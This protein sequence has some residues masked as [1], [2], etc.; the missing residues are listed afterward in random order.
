M[1]K[2]KY[3]ILTFPGHL[4]LIMD[5]SQVLCTGLSKVLDSRV[6]QVLLTVAQIT[7]FRL[8][9]LHLCDF[10]SYSPTIRLQQ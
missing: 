10:S 1:Q 2:R 6:P 4:G 8:T 5:P 7:S 9:L 3:Q